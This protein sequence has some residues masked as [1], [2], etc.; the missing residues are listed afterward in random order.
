MLTGKWEL[1]YVRTYMGHI[2]GQWKVKG[3]TTYNYETERIFMKVY[4]ILRYAA[5]GT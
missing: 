5:S 3:P 4:R 2:F 1:K